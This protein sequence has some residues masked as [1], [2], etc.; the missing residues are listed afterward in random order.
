MSQGTI[1]VTYVNNDGGGFASDKNVPA[2]TTVQQFFREHMAGKDESR[3]HIRVNRQ[4][5]SGEQTLQNGDKIS[6]TP[7]KIEGAKVK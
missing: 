2:G 7:T 5:V 1:I 6:I 4:P 3:Y